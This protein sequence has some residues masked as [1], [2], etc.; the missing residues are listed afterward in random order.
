MDDQTITTKKSNMSRLIP[1][2]FGI[3][4]SNRDFTQKDTWG[5][6]QFNSSFPASLVCYIASKNLQL[7]YLTLDTAGKVNHSYLDHKDLFGIAYN[8][9]DL[10]FAFESD[11]IPFQ[12]LVFNSLPRIDLVTMNAKTNT[13]L[14]GIEI[15]LTALPDNSTCLLSE[16]KYCSEIVC[17]PDTIVYMALSIILSLGENQMFLRDAMKPLDSIKDWSQG[18]N[19]I[20]FLSLMSKIVDDLLTQNTQRQSP[21]VLQPIWKTN[22]KSQILNDNAFDVFVWSDFA[23]AQLFLSVVRGELNDDRG[24]I[25]RQVRS[26]IWLTKMLYDYSMNGMINHR[27][28]IDELSYNTKNDKAFAVSGKVVHPYMIS[29][30]LISPR[31]KK[32][33]IRNIIL[34][35]GHNLLSPERRLDAVILSTPGLFE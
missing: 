31:I 34:N 32:N 30:E 23:F 7:N 8:D 13:C 6:N 33:E 18:V 5:K 21:L 10:F 15:K 20:P 25:T 14:R 19:V 17:R 4:N 22:G 28:V 35:G 24:K 3:N 27:T 29:Q 11:Y 16:D 12:R 9:P 26:V 2:L 1:S